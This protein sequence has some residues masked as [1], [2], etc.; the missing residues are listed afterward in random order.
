MK[1]SQMLQVIKDALY[2]HL[3]QYKECPDYIAETVLQSIEGG[4]KLGMGM[5]PPDV[6]IVADGSYNSE[7]HAAH[8]HMNKD[9]HYWEKE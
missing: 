9:L 8:F 4:N 3:P 7:K 2:C 6:C 1:R 5:L